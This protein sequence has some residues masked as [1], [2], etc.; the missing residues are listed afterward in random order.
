MR[1]II[2]LLTVLAL[3]LVPGSPTWGQDQALCPPVPSPVLRLPVLTDALRRGEPLIIAAFGSSST[4][5]AKASDRGHSYPAILQAELTRQ[6][7]G[8]HVA[9]VNRGVGGEDAS[10]ELVRL[11][12]DVAALRPHLVIWQVGANAAL[13]DVDPV[14]FAVTVKA[15][16]RRLQEIGADVILMDNQRAP[17]VLAAP[18]HTAIE[19]A[20][21]D[22]ADEAGVSFFSRGALMDAWRAA[23]ADYGAFLVDDGVHHNDRGYRCLADSLTK[24]I[25]AAVGRE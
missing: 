11:G 23:G 16:V 5:G 18:R 19:R 6:L 17:R 20:I 4:R 9:V 8:A 22:V 15:G 24:A 21:A 25:V 2:G 10:R 13:R 12:R 7:P 1:V 3:G 14:S